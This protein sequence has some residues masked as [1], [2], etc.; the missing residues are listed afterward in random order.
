MITQAK[1]WKLSLEIPGNLHDFMGMFFM[2][3]SFFKLESFLRCFK[4]I[5]HGPTG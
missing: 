2:V 4:L 3:F 5:G 1:A